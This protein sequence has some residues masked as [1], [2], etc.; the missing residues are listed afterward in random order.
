MKNKPLKNPQATTRL[1]RR[2]GTQIEQLEDRVV[3]SGSSIVQ[4]FSDV[5]DYGD[6][7]DWALNAV[8]APEVWA[9]GFTG[10]GVVVAV[11]DSGVDL[12]HP[13]LVDSIWQNEGE[14]AANGID[15]DGNGFV[16]DRAGWDFVN[17]DRLAADV[18][19]H[20]THV[21]GIVAAARND[22]GATGVAYGAR[23]MPVRVL[24]GVGNGSQVDIASGIRYA[25]DNGADIVNLSLGG[26]TGS[27]RVSR[28]I[29]HALDHDVLIVAA[30]GNAGNETPDFPAAYSE[31]FG[32]VISVGAHDKNDL[33]ASFS[34]GVG[35]S[36]AV[37]IDAPGVSVY[38]TRVEGGFRYGSGTSYA[39]PVVSGVAALMLSANP[40]LSAVDLRNLLVTHAT[41]T[42]TGTDT[43]GGL[44]AAVVVSATLPTQSIPTASLPG[45]TDG[46]G[47]VGLNDFLVV[48]RNFGQQVSGLADG[49]FNGDGIVEFIDFLVLTRNFGNTVS[50][51]NADSSTASVDL[52]LASEIDIAQDALLDELI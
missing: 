10:A 35:D 44:N 6:E 46:D 19:G 33:V 26:A 5:D 12:Q 31:Q 30:S 41:A 20:G 45:D 2:H 16:D 21:T 51:A 43:L 11:I 17:D 27:Q 25:V 24:D 49:D 29:Q 36:G 18:A 23:I 4:P 38:S 40:E 39:T 34:N 8:N 7:K 42:I 3:L 28:A 1:R 9:R 48:S 15:D 13:D 47:V 50:G 37:Q 14:I 32:N 22:S 52:A